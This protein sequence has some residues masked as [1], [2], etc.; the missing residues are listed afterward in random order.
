MNAGRWHNGLW[1]SGGHDTMTKRLTQSAK[2]YFKKRRVRGFRLK[3]LFVI[4]LLSSL[5]IFVEWTLFCT[6][7]KSQIY[8]LCEVTLLNLPQLHW[9]CWLYSTAYQCLESFP[10]GYSLFFHDSSKKS[11]VKVFWPYRVTIVPSSL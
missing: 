3:P 8:P 5:M 9:L 7:Y 2:I 1:F 4:W 10:P 11:G 6:N